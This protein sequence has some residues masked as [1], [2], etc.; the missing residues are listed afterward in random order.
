M[1]PSPIGVNGTQS[2][3][4][5]ERGSLILSDR[6]DQRELGAELGRV[7]FFQV[8]SICK[9]FSSHQKPW[10]TK[11]RFHKYSYASHIRETEAERNEEQE[12]TQD[13][14]KGGRQYQVA[15]LLQNYM[16]LHYSY[17]QPEWLWLWEYIP[18]K[19]Y[20]TILDGNVTTWFGWVFPLTLLVFHYRALDRFTLVVPGNPVFIILVRSKTKGKGWVIHCLH[21][22][23][24]TWWDV[25]HTGDIL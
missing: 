6:K 20:V 14:K 17:E 1:L 24:G 25:M 12:S 15:G 16:R 9:L 18:T 10:K 21:T 11:P 5:R 7:V 23:S 2:Q 3:G 22:P 13:A 4:G 19:K 8:R